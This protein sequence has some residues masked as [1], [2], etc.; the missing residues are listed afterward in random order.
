[1]PSSEPG[2]RSSSGASIGSKLGSPA[3]P[4]A[5]LALGVP[6]RWP[7]ACRQRQQAGRGQTRSGSEERAS[8]PALAQSQ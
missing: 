3:T 6:P 1:M 2:T 8:E 4:C 5:P 7:L